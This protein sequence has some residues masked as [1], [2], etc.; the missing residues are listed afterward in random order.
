[1]RIFIMARSHKRSTKEAEDTS[2]VD[3]R[4]MIVATTSAT[5]DVVGSPPA[6]IKPS[7]P[8]SNK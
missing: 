3:R 1:V 8:K 6:T 5:G 7:W 2:A 4:A